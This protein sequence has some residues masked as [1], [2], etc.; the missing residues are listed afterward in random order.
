M[1][2]SSL[3][4]FRADGWG[5]D[6]TVGGHVEGILLHGYRGPLWQVSQMRCQ[7]ESWN[8]TSHAV[9][10]QTCFRNTFQSL[11]RAGHFVIKLGEK[12]FAE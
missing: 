12:E 10:S 6:T 4:D 2:S 1:S 11:A 3:V 9:S 7:P 8:P 5:M